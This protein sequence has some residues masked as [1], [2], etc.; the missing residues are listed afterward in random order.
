[1]LITALAVLLV[2]ATCTSAG[3]LLQSSMSAAETTPTMACCAG[4]LNHSGNDGPAHSSDHHCP[5]CQHTVLLAKA[6]DHAQ[7][8]FSLTILPPS[9]CALSTPMFSARPAFCSAP[10]R[11]GESPGESRTLVDL[12][13]ALLI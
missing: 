6:I 7:H 13:C 2:S 11:G 3:C 5:L 10:P 9:F 12:H 1:M 4:H 8:D